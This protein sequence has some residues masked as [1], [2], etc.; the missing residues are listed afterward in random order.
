[1]IARPYQILGSQRK[2]EVLKL[3]RILRKNDQ[4]FR[5]SQQELAQVA[6]KSAR[7]ESFL[8]WIP[9]MCKQMLI[10]LINFTY[11]NSRRCWAI[12]LRK[13]ISY[14]YWD[15]NFKFSQYNADIVF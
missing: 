1:M 7:M 3:H 13:V 4:R 5:P 11:N 6:Y 14:V 10:T 8:F 2:G 15:S 12:T 9:N